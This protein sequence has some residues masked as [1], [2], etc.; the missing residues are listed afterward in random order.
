MLRI[1]ETGRKGLC[2]PLDRLTVVSE[3]EGVWVVYDGVNRPYLRRAGGA[4][5]SFRVGG[6]P[7][8]QRVE[9]EDKQGRRLDSAAFSVEARTCLEDDGGQF[10]Q[11]LND[12]YWT[13]LDGCGSGRTAP[14]I[15]WD[16]RFY[17]YLNTWLRDHT[18]IMKGRK[19]FRRELKS[20]FD[21]H[22]RAQRADGMVFD[23]I[24]IPTSR[25]ADI[26]QLM[27]GDGG[28]V[29]MIENGRFK[30]ERIPVENDVE[31]LFLECLYFTWKATGDDAW[32]IGH[33]DNA[34]RA[35]EYSTTDPYRWSEKFG[36]LKRGF[37]IDTWDFQAAEDARI[38]GHTMV[39]DKELTRFGVM[40]GDNTGFAAG[41][42]YLAEM[43][44]HAGRTD[45]ARRI[46]G[47]AAD[48]RRRLDELAWNGRFFTHHVPED[49]DVVR[50]LGVNQD[51]QISLSNAYALNRG[52][53]HEQAVAIIRKYQD[54]RRR[55][56]E[57]SPGEWYQIFPPFER[58]FGT[59]N[60]RWEYCNGGVTTLVA[61]ELAR[62]AFEH[63]FES[64]GVDILDRI[65]RISARHEHYLHGTYRGAMPETPPRRFTAMDL[66]DA[67]NVDFFG[68]GAENV[69]GWAGEGPENDLRE[70]PTGHQTFCDIPVDVIDPAANGRRACIG[71][72]TGEGYAGRVRLKSGQKAASLYLLHTMAGGPEA[73]AITIRYDD[74]TEWT[75]YI[76]RDRI[77]R[78]WMPE[79]SLG[80]RNR[81]ARMAWRGANA[82]CPDVAVTICGLNNPHPDKVIDSI[83]LE[84]RRDGTMWF[85]LGITLCDSH[86]FFPP[87]EI[88]SGIPDAW[89]AAAVTY[90]LVEGLA[91]VRDAGRAFDSVLLAPRWSAAGV[92]KADVT[93]HYP[94]SDGYVSYSYAVTDDGRSIE[95]ELT[96]N[97]GRFRT[98]VLLPA[99][100]TCGRAL[101]DGEEVG[102][103]HRTMEES[104]YAC[105]EV[106][107]VGVHDLRL[108]L[109]KS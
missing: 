84:A 17:H 6:T 104:V 87:S 4:S 90:A 28:F 47:L 2:R 80:Q 99:G 63:G 36:L 108:E 45:E 33:L 27:F 94:A 15:R 95:V 74:A 98:E 67:A 61:G 49:P 58:G 7:G 9:L 77:T 10:R 37:T 92:K 32:M 62:G 66:R 50:D 93:I 89:G 48:I 51:E 40:H 56:P 86:V 29:K 68:E 16:G 34:L 13:M 103:R 107:G 46:A 97:A 102:V 65:A 8:C 12:L 75:G 54:L 21:M 72:G 14:Q 109:E 35:V 41:C 85:V 106:E 71:L 52:I 70:M 24:A 30:F 60:G 31:Y 57:S 53:S 5:L 23:K 22:A 25:R 59:H 101:L 44:G 76:G 64:Y 39:I 18:H 38:T 81:S 55:M 79:E 91:G 88:S 105:L 11:L 100:A 73:G 78:W 42:D 19:Y 82:T 83:T 69:V 26:R 1:S 20:A 3:R 96:G 43:L